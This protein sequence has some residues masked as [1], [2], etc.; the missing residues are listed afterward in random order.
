[1]NGDW[2][3]E[4]QMLQDRNQK[5]MQVL[6]KCS[7]TRREV[8]VIYCQCYLLAVTYPL[9]TAIIPIKLDD[10]QRGITTTFLNKMGY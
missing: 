1:M 2:K 5:Y 7:L 8:T 6:T 10:E 9:P 3:K 4:L